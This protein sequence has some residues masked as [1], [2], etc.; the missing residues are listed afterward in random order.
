MQSP[1]I[2]PGPGRS[3]IRVQSR[4]ARGRHRP[5]VTQALVT[6]PF[7]I[8]KLQG[9]RGLRLLG[10]PKLSAV[11]LRTTSITSLGNK[12]F[13][14]CSALASIELPAGLTSIGDQ[15]F[16]ACSALASIELPAGLTSLGDGAFQ[17]CRSLASIELP[18]GLTSIGT[19]AFRE[20]SSLASIELPTGLTSLGNY[21]F[22]GCSSLASI[23][24]PTGLTS[25]GRY[26]AI[27]GTTTVTRATATA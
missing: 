3:R 23:E 17:G 4:H 20:C 15:A 1:S 16:L 2:P 9:L 14:G 10:C 11:D 6:L 21:A 5:G 25:I 22:D 24:L 8:G 13:L 12:A 18:A 27:P 19:Q 7:G 26:Y